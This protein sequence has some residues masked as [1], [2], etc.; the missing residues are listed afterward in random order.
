MSS[1]LTRLSSLGRP[2]LAQLLRARVLIVRKKNVETTK[3]RRAVSGTTNLSIHH[4][5][6]H[7]SVTEF[8]HDTQ[9]HDDLLAT[10]STQAAARESAADATTFNSCSDRESEEEHT[11]LALLNCPNCT[12][13]CQGK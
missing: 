7:N 4:V 3:Y 2:T 1:S 11:A 10:V 13:C 8:A 12:G 5:K 6:D 9:F